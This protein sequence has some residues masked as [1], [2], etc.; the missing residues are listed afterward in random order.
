MKKLFFASM[1]SLAGSMFLASCDSD[2]KSANPAFNT[3]DTTSNY[4]GAEQNTGTNKDAAADRELTT[5]D[6]PNR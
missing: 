3:N 4:Q 6:T 5:D 2:S 1:L